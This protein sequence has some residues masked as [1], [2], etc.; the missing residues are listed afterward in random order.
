MVEI[1]RIE[2]NLFGACVVR[3]TQADGFE[4][5]GAKH[6]ALFAL[7]ATAPFGRRTRPFLQDTLWGTACYDTGRQSLRRALSDIRQIMG[8]CFTDVLSSTNSDLTLDLARVS[9][10]GRPGSGELLEG[11]NLKED[12]FNSWLGAMRQ[13]PQQI[14]SLYGCSTQSLAAPMLPFVAVLPFRTIGGTPEHAVLGDW[15]AEE[16]SR[17]LSRSNLTS[18]ISHWSSRALDHRAV[19]IATV[20]AQL[21]VDY[22]LVG[23]LRVATR[24]IILDADLVDTISGRILWTRQFAGP[25]GRF[26][27]RCAEGVAEIVR[28]IGATVADDAISHVSDRRLSDVEDH[29]LLVAGV[30]LMHRPALRDF[31]RSRELIEET[32]K[33]APNAAEAHAWF[34][35][36]H[37]LSVFNGW[38]TDPAKDTRIALDST[39]RALDINPDNAFCLTIDGFAHNNL[40][41]RMDIASA[42][43]D[44]ALRR[45]PNEALAWLLKGALNA[46]QDHGPTAVT[47]AERARRLSPIDPFRYYYESLSA[48]ALLSAGRYAEALDF[49]E[50]SLQ[51]HHRH[52]STLRTKIV[53]LHNLG[54][55]EDAKR[56]ASDLLTRQPHFTVSAYRRDHPAA[57]Y[58]FGKRAAEALSAAGIPS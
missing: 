50:C 40:L 44:E 17:S 30:G 11:I 1:K 31:A 51:R 13:N 7:L 25:I 12:G 32:L 16:V 41:R 49:A 3:S 29:R 47:A 15:L 53:A 2:I 28:A 21:A 33:R 35:K 56:A 10:I 23:T 46:F 42:R 52:I 34:G 14:Y 9:F 5:T 57:D 58:N 43:Y 24:E 26:M 48:T 27:D 22:C 54:R 45:N 6:K 19:D 8:D 20:R 36:W 37:A 55:N 39:A 18:V 38:S 4:I